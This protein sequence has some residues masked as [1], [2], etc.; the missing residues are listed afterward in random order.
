MTIS[1]LDSLKAAL[2]ARMDHFA[3]VGCR[4]ADISFGSP[5]FTVWD[6][7]LAQSALAKVLAG[8]VAD[9]KE[10]AAYQSY[11]MDFVGGEFAASDSGE[12]Q[13]T[14]YGIS[15]TLDITNSTATGFA[16]VNN[17][18]WNELNNN[19]KEPTKKFTITV[20]GVKAQ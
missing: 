16:D 18:L 2:S 19:T 4:L 1:D 17:G 14:E 12:I 15:G 20:D 3:G 11:V 10:T 6:P 5:D 9:G 13:M 8:G 7:D